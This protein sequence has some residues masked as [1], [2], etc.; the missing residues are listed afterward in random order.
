MSI[1]VCFLFLIQYGWS[2]TD[3]RRLEYG[4]HAV[5]WPIAIALA[6]YGW[7]SDV[8][9]PNYEGTGGSCWVNEPLCEEDICESEE[10]STMVSITAIIIL[11][12][13]VGTLYILQRVYRTAR[14]LA[15]DNKDALYGLTMKGVFYTAIVAEAA[16]P[17]ILISIID[18][19]GVDNQGVKIVR[20][21]FG[22][23]LVVAVSLLS[24]QNML[25]FLWRRGGM[26]TSYGKCYHSIVFSRNLPNL[27]GKVEPMTTTVSLDG[28]P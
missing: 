18:T 11:L 2:E 5:V 9:R 22:Q 17:A 10:V 1:S 24:F 28:S 14:Q 16:V 21:I 4:M 26:M 27:I 23:I 12:H 20:F 15:V 6:I 25:T 13:F 3:L 7:E 19:T 8:Y